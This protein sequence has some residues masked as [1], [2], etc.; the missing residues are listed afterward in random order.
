LLA[1]AWI[2]VP[3]TLTVPTLL[4][5]Q[6]LGQLQDAHKRRLERALVGVRNVQIES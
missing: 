6:L 1:L 3:S 5:A 2:F 4:Q